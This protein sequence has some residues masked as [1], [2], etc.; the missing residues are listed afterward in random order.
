TE[1]TRRPLP[2]YSTT[3]TGR[4]LAFAKWVANRDNP[5]TARVAVNHIWLRH[6]GQAIVP[7]VFDFGR[8]G[9][10]PSHPALLDWLAVELMEH[11]WSTKHLHRLIVTS[12]GYRMATTP[13]AADLAKDPD[14]RYLW[15]MNS[16]RLEAEAV[17]DGIF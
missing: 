13:D 1:Y 17:R 5:L 2:A 16:R 7:S 9:Q 11:K 12:S 14:N 10:G 4:R 8:N 6:F 3:S 15:R